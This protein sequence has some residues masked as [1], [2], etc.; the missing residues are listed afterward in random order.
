VDGV[1]A[2]AGL[3]AIC[4]ETGASGIVIGSSAHGPIGRVLMG[5]VGGRLASGSSCPVFVAPR[6]YS[7]QGSAGLGRIG[8]G[9]NGSPES[10]I[11]LDYATGL[12][13]SL[14]SSLN[15]IGAVPLIHAGGRIGH[16]GIGYQQLIR[17]QLETSLTE[18]TTAAGDSG[19]EVSHELRTGDP[20]D[21]L[22]EATS[23][24]D[25][26]VLGSRGYGPLLRV[27]LGGVSLK[28]MRSS[29]CPVIVVPRGG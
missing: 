12:A 25:L 14:G 29:A 20:A 11:A 7:R 23:D 26:L 10:R 17:D 27:M 21:C 15:L 16:T 28:A 4:E 8:V 18:A 9:F 3:T 19:L 6:G 2:P 22:V 5:D 13:G 24:L 1:T